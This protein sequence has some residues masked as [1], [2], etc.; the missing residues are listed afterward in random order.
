MFVVGIVALAAGWI[1]VS[2]LERREEAKRQRLREEFL[3]GGGNAS[4]VA[5]AGAG[6]Q[7]ADDVPLPRIDLKF[8]FSMKE[9]FITMTVAAVTLGL[10]RW[11]GVDK[12]AVALGLVALVG[13]IVQ[14]TGFEAPRFVALGWWLL[15]MMYLVVGLVAAFSPPKQ[16]ANRRAEQPLPQMLAEALA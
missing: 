14:A 7:S 13:L 16:S 9:L 11:I 8:A 12:M 5:V 2:R 15:L 10:I 4:A 3:A 6:G 1:Y